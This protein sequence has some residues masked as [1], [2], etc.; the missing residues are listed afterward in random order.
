MEIILVFCDGFFDFNNPTI[1]QKIG[2]KKI[3]NNKYQIPAFPF[4][5]RNQKPIINKITVTSEVKIVVDS[6][7]SILVGGLA[8][9]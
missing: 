1:I 9:Y 3:I 8:P 7:D 4:S 5:L 6:I 2:V